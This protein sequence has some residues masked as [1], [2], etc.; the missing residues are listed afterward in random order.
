MSALDIGARAL[1]MR[2]LAQNAVRFADLARAAVPAN[3]TVLQ[4]AGHAAIGWGVACYIND[5]QATAALAANFPL[6]VFQAADGRYFRLRGDYE[7]FITPEQVG[8]GIY[9]TGSDQ[10]PSIQ[11][12]LDYCKAVGLRG[13]KFPQRNYELWAPTRTAAFTANLDHSGN[14]LVVDQW[15]CS[16]VGMAADRTTFRCKGPTGGSL[17]TDYQVLNTATYGGDVIWRGAGLKLTGSVSVGLP[18]PDTTQLSHATVRNIRFLSD[19]VGTRNTNWPS[20]PPSRD[21]TRVNCWDISNKGIYYQQDVHVGNC[22]LENVEISG[23]LG[24]CLYTGGTGGTALNVCEI[25]LRDVICRNSNGQALNPNGPALF[26]VD[27]LY[28]ENCGFSIEG[29]SGLI[30]GRLVNA[31]FKDCNTGTLTGGWGYDGSLRSDNSLPL[32]SIDATFENCGDLAIGSYMTGNLRLIDTRLAVTPQT[33][34]TVVQGC[35]LEIVSICNKANVTAAIRFSGTTQNIRNNRF[36]ILCQKSKYAVDN[37]KFFNALCTQA[38]SIGPNN[39]IYAAGEVGTI[40]SVSAVT[41]NYVAILD[42]GMDLSPAGAPVFF[43]PTVTPS[44]DMGAGWVRAGTFSTGNGVFTVNLPATTMYQEGAEIVVEHR[45]STKT[46]AFIELA[47]GAGK[48]ALLGYKDRAKFRCNRLLARWDMILA[49]APRSATASVALTSTALAAESGP[50]TIALP[51]CRPW[52]KA[53]VIPPSLMT[54]FGITAVRAET[55]QVKF[56]VKNY[57]GAN[58]ATLAALTY[59]A[60]CSVAA[61]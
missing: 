47:D 14:F 21:P 55:D 3:T 17:A 33:A 52:H 11:L 39:F 19:T 24:E 6:A 36:R 44:P 13:V 12:A 30:Y 49:P 10:R 48:R 1:A 40:G 25:R 53:E 27:G 54:G 57:D 9:A 20:Y 29:A 35:N 50:Y 16:L 2:A 41:D 42:A 58:P 7:G 5:A 56:W 31:Y 23:F 60:R 45:D 51:G 34:A 22:T 59:T 61:V 26:D 46:A 18:R 38:G 43:D 15:D 28:A 8:C 4:S 32:L 37:S